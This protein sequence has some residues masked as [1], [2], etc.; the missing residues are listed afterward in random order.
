MT[1]PSN[2]QSLEGLAPNPGSP[3]AT[4]QGCLC[5]VIDNH[6]GKG[7]PNG[8]GPPLFWH[9][10]RCPLHGDLRFIDKPTALKDAS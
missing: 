4:A 7:V 9:S 3:E 1:T 6:H 5:P 10:V 2:E 8:D